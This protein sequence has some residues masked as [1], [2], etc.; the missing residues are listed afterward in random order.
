MDF[1]DVAKLALIVATPT[2]LGAL[3]IYAPKWCGAV[4]DR[5]EAARPRPPAPYGPPIE[6]LA[7]D[8]RRLL[9]LHS[10]LTASAHLAMRAHRLWAV[11]AAI[12]TRAVEAA[13]ALGLPHPEPGRH[14]TL[15]RRQL[16]DLLMRLAAA[17]LV[18]PAKVGPFT[19]DGRI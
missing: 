13:R 16:H 6:Q 19:S 3:V 10:E 12:G 18:L 11:E 2:L 17:G 9:R 14:D 15:T 4:A 5:W 7:A 8:L 1:W